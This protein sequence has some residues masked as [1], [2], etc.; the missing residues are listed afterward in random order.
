[1]LMLPVMGWGQI[2]LFSDDF[3]TS[4]GSAFT[5]S[6]GSIGSDPNWL[7]TRSGDDWGAR[8][9]DNIMELT[10][11]ASG[12][13]NANG[14]VFGYR[15]I[16]ALSGWHTTLSAN[17]GI[18]TWEFNLRQIRDNPA[19]FGTGSYGVAFI[20]AGTNISPSAAGSGYAIVLGQSGT[21]DP[22]RLAHYNNGLSGTLTNVITSST[23]GLT[24]F[25]FEYLSVRVTYDPT[26]NTWE[27]FL[28]SDGTTAFA[29]P[30][31]GT[32]TSQGTAVNNTYTSTA[33]MRYI[34]GY[35]QG[36]TAASQTAFFDNVYLKIA[37]SATPDIAISTAHPAS[38][39]I[40]QASTNNILASYQLDVSSAG[41]TLTGI[42][43]TTA[44]TYTVDDIATN[45]F[46]FWINSS[47]NLA[48]ATQLGSSQAAVG[49]GGTVAVSSLSQ[50]VPIGT[51]YILVTA[52]IAS[53]ATPSNT[54]SIATTAFAN[55]TFA[56]A[57]KTGTD[58]AAAS[59]SMTIVACTPSNATG[60]TLTPANSQLTVGWTN[61]G[62][63]D[64]V[65]IVAKASSSITT[66]PTGNGSLYS[67]SLSFGSGT[68][69]DGGHV[70]Y[71]GS[72]S[73]L[74][75]TGLTN[76]TTYFVKV[77]TRKGT[78]WSSGVESSAT[79]IILNA[80]TI[81]WSS[82]AGSAWLTGS[83]WTG[84]DVP[85]ASQVAQFETNPTATTGVGI[86]FNS[87]TNAG[88]QINGQRIQ[89]VGAVEITNTRSAAMLIGN[90]STTAGATGQFRLNGVAVNS[91]E[92]VVLRNNSSQNLTIQNTQASGNQTMDVILNNSVDNI[93]RLDGTGN[94]TI[95]SVIASA[96]GPVTIA[97][98]G[99][100]AVIFS[101]QNTYT[102]H[103]NIAGSE[104]RLN[105]MG[106]NTLPATNSITVSG[107]ILRIS[108]NQTLNNLTLTSG[109]I[110]VDAGVTLTINGTITRT[111]GSIDASAS[112]ATIVFGNASPITLPADLFSGAVHNLLLGSG[113]GMVT[114]GGN[115]T[116]NGQL[117]I[118]SGCRLALGAGNTLTLNGTL[119]LVG[120]IRGGNN[121]N[122]IIAGS[123]SDIS[124]R[125]DQTTRGITNRLGNLTYNRA[126]QTITLLDTL[127]VVGVITPT[128]GQLNTQHML[129]LISTA[130]GTA[131][132]AMG[133]GAYITG[134][135]VAERF[136]PATGG[137]R[138]RF[139]ASPVTNAT[140]ED[141]R[142][143]IFI[144][145]GSGST[146]LGTT[147]TGGFDA[148]PN[149]SPGIFSYNETD[150]SPNLNIGWVAPTS[151]TDMLTPGVGYRL[152]VRG[153]RSNTARLTNSPPPMNEVTMNVVGPVNT[154]NITIPVT[155]SGS[156]VGNTYNDAADGWNLL[157]NPY[158][159]DYDWNAF[160]DANSTTLGLFLEPTIWV[161]NATTGGYDSYNANSNSGSLTSGIIP[162]GA[163]FWVKANVLGNHNIT[164]TEAFKTNTQAINV[165]KHTEDAGFVVRMARD[166]INSSELHI[167]YKAGATTNFERM[168]IR[169][170]PGSVNIASY[171]ADSVRLSASVR[172]LTTLNDTIRLDVS[173]SNGSYTFIF[174]NPAY[175]DILDEVYLIDNHQN[176]VVNLKQTNQYSFAIS[177]SI[178]TTFGAN[179]FMIVVANA[180]PV[181]VSLAVFNATATSNKEIEL[182]WVTVSEINSNNFEIEHS[183]NGRQFNSIGS[184]KA[185]G[186]SSAINT[187]HFTHK[188]AA[189]VN[190][191]RLKMV[192]MDGSYTTSPTRM[193]RFDGDN[194]TEVSIW[195]IPASQQISLSGLSNEEDICYA[196]TDAMGQIISSGIWKANASHEL[197]IENLPHGVYFINVQS[198]I[199]NNT[200]RFVKH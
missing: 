77:F 113:A 185:K 58:P 159:S 64:E 166:S 148:S 40:A 175:I 119:D 79:P 18:V 34:G 61:P 111:G 154:G 78:S 121:S 139:M 151:T 137:R 197:W 12:T 152:F 22:V 126:S 160:Y 81:L 101:G 120:D 172:P 116:I 4:R 127:E 1:M 182:N 6:T 87:T 156:G 195:P 150:L 67:A 88:V 97:G 37:S 163:A 122:L 117:Q 162:S 62:C 194:K 50:A 32:L 176:Q 189:V 174:Q 44:G 39:N 29:N 30:T 21:T 55:I 38:T 11:D 130:A 153:D 54:I 86:N 95:S 5:T 9:H 89:E 42:S 125:M 186:N 106:G 45:G 56:S 180:N 17:T 191:Y 165:F 149:N 15:D 52:D 63:L 145:G 68:A 133:T 190:Y 94:I 110:V 179:R 59:N 85:A 46:K 8:I 138:W 170:L 115:T 100:G 168:D 155:C 193:V 157:G 177:S 80:T 74:I 25:G 72:A 24:D 53:G 84:S 16:N 105:H 70:V 146:T 171:G 83:N 47:N 23:S 13:T 181:P 51:R 169:Q 75:I 200:F 143:E 107:G 196:I 187:Y 14:W 41:A 192:D 91:I 199:N 49:S 108:S 96:A 60:L 69:F 35:W 103:T 129:K 132:I 57:N 27:L 7:M 142:G 112:G 184:V 19:G 65:M 131:R 188:D 43:V 140:I 102:T 178:P 98:S 109:S 147:N 144:T 73:P 93:I 26:T 134:N 33:G 10:N 82:P 2:T 90:S 92:N 99:S 135:V 36:S 183:T 48:G 164:L 173:G 124:I 167:K 76:G 198:A 3:N 118:P 114:L 20:L 128:A 136:V 123:G 158:P 66:A 161:Y 104:L 28:R 71:K 141:W 31:T